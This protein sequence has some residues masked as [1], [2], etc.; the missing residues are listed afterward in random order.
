M[1]SK[2]GECLTVVE[3]AGVTLRTLRRVFATGVRLFARQ[4]LIQG[5]NV[6]A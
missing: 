3:D 4:G 1:T 5:V 2:A 6:T